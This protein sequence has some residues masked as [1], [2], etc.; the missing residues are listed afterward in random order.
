[1]TKMFVF[2]FLCHQIKWRRARNRVKTK[3]MTK[4]V[5]SVPCLV[6]LLAAKHKNYWMD[7]HKNLDGGFCTSSLNFWC[8]S[9]ERDVFITFF[10]LV[11]K[12]SGVLS[13]LVSISER[14]KETVWPW[15]SY[16]LYWGSIL[17]IK[18]VACQFIFSAQRGQSHTRE[19]SNEWIQ[20]NVAG[21][22]SSLL[23]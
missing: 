5:F 2:N 16:A 18:W 22:F 4:Y 12:T 21:F 10:Y 23:H 11:R 20:I 13:W 9:R 15:R 14:Q 8:E 3:T 17:V 1:M 6:V 7:F 19:E